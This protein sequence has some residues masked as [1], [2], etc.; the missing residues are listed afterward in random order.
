MNNIRS[1][2]LLSAVICVGAVAGRDAHA[3][4]VPLQTSS[5]QN[6]SESLLV[7]ADALLKAHKPA[8]AYALLA[9]YQTERAGE[10]AYDYLLGIAALDSGK[11]NEAIF[12]LERVLAVEPGNLQARAEIAKAYLAA[13]EAATSKREFEIVQQQNPPREVSATIQK[14]LDIIETARAGMATTVRGYVEATLGDD[15]NVNSATSSSQIALPL[16]GGSLWNL[17]ADGIARRDTFNNIGAGFSVRRPLYRD[18]AVIGGANANQRTNS[19]AHSFDTGSLDAT[20]GVSHTRGDNI[21]SA[22]LQVQSF[23]LRSKRYRDAAGVTGQW[24]RNAGNSSQVS[25]YFQ[26]TYL[27]YPEQSV[28]NVDRY[29]LGG[30]YARLLDG[31]FSPS[32]YIGAYAGTEKERQPNVPYLGDKLYGVRTGGELKLNAQTTLTGSASVEQRNYGGQDPLFLVGRSD[33]QSDLKLG[34]TYIPAQRWTITPSL[35]YTH[36]RS[37]VTINQYD[38]TVFS[39]SVRRDFN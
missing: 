29:V 25:I 23:D 5:N 7:E 17:N 2:C 18:W 36:T 31:K 4:A 39:V 8:A 33:T 14:Y 12:A 11:L 10:P 21:Y 13:G 37:N 1:L 38:R 20:L 28:R 3:Q 35:A 19:S 34:V 26:Y 24:Q 22:A 32:V 30:A 9:P 27:S 6:L 15:S 16:F